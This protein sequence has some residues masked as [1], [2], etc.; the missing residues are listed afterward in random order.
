MLPHSIFLVYFLPFIVFSFLLSAP[1]SRQ[2]RIPLLRNAYL[3]AARYGE[4]CCWMRWALS[5]DTHLTA[6]QCVSTSC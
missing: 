1:S 4:R 2:M 5:L 6:A 3:R